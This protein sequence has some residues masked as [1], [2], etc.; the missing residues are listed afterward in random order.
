MDFG[1]PPP[2]SD[3][4]PGPSSGHAIYNSFCFSSSASD[5]YILTAATSKGK[6][7]AI[8]PSPSYTITSI[9]MPH[10]PTSTY[11][12]GATQPLPLFLPPLSSPCFAPPNTPR[13][14]HTPSSYPSYHP[15]LPSFSVHTSHSPHS[16]L[17]PRPLVY[18][19]PHVMHTSTHSIAHPTPVYTPPMT[20]HHT[21]IPLHAPCSLLDS[22]ASNTST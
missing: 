9:S 8:I 6:A 15:L 20:P 5:T 10:I 16:P 7:P 19:S 22:C 2:K 1:F 18:A 12:N 17:V 4:L 11:R 3:P 21:P 14:F 13:T